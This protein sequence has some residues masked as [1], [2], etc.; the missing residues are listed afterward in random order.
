MAQ[1]ASIPP[2]PTGKAKTPPEAKPGALSGLS[3]AGQSDALEP[4]TLRF[5]NSIALAADRQRE[6]VPPQYRT[7]VQYTSKR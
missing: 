2:I 5:Q 3:G 1:E 4:V 6:V 7:F